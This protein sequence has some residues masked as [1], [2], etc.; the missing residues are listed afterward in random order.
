MFNATFDGI[1]VSKRIFAVLETS[2]LLV[3][4]NE[5]VLALNFYHATS[6]V[7]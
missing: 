7:Q 4:V 1:E 6:L 3:I 2:Y 5:R